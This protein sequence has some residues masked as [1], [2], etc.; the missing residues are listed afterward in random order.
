MKHGSVTAVQSNSR[1]NNKKET[2]IMSPTDK[3]VRDDNDILDCLFQC[4][5]KK[6]IAKT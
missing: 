1:T 4:K 3:G 2:M 6:H 5:F